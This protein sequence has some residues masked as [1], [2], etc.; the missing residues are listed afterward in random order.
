VEQDYPAGLQAKPFAADRWGHEKKRISLYGSTGH[1]G[2]F[3]VGDVNAMK[4]E[5]GDVRRTVFGMH[6]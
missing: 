4:G 1:I 5:W 6:D 2:N 3:Y